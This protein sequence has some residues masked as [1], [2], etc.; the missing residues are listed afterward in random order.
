MSIAAEWKTFN[1]QQRNAFV[2]SYLG[3]TLDAFDFFLMVFVLRAV[4]AEFH[5]DVKAVSVAV[6]LTLA[7]RP[8]G[9]LVF[10]MLGDRFGRR[11]VLMADILLFSILELASAFAPSLTVLLILRAAFGFAMGGE[12]GLGASLTMET[13]PTKSRGAV[14]GVLQVG[15][16]SGFLLASVVYGLLFDHVGWRGMFMVGVLP[17]LLVVFIRR[18]VEESPAWHKIRAR[19]RPPLGTMVKNHWILFVYIVILMTSFNFFS[20]GTQDLY[21]TFLQAQR[22]FDTKTVSTI[23]IIA[24]IGAI[25]GGLTFGAF[26]QRIGRRRAIVTAALCALPIIPLWAFSTNIALIALGAFLIQMCVQGAW[27]VIPVHLNELSPDEVRATFP[28]FTYQLGNLLA[29][30]N[31]TIQADFA[32]SR[33]GN[34]ALAL[35]VVG[36]IAA[37]SVA[38]LAFIGR[39]KHSVEFGSEAS[40]IAAT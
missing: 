13:I 24:N 23:A 30:A 4:A 32:E 36:G 34:Y 1:P 20:H 37:I 28:A 6:T 33:G 22:K 39:E 3:W 38:T 8:L 18:N 9:A 11:P 26:S 10:G 7:M 31:A 35:A 14:S 12:W 5:S 40:A 19:P 17:A 16:P 21:P 29:S 27:G 2:A 25:I 15:Y